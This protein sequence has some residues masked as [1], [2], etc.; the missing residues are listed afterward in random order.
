VLQYFQAELA[1]RKAEKDASPEKAARPDV[2]HTRRDYSL[3]SLAQVIQADRVMRK[4][5]NVKI[6]QRLLTPMEF[7]GTVYNLAGQ[8][9]PWRPAWTHMMNLNIRLSLTHGSRPLLLPA[10]AFIST[11]SAAAGPGTIPLSLKILLFSP[12]ALCC[13]VPS[14]T[15]RVRRNTSSALVGSPE[16]AG[17]SSG[18]SDPAAAAETSPWVYARID[19]LCNNDQCNAA[20]DLR[21]CE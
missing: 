6:P 16:L 20:V 13:P 4:L 9:S 12:K 11:G 8:R 7:R 10:D 5:E 21:S 19:F 3:R 18:R 1:A 17:R 15:C 14:L 2:S